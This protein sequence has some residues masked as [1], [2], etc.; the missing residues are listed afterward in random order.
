MFLGHFVNC[1]GFVSIFSSLFFKFSCSLMTIF[2]VIFGLLFIICMCVSIVD[3]W[4]AVMSGF[5]TGPSIYIQD[6][7]KL[8]V[9]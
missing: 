8:L 7:F 9:S 5:D 1:F 4:F 6:C 2:S 3:F